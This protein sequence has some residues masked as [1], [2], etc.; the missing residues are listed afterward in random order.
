MTE[1]DLFAAPSGETAHG[2]PYPTPDDTVNVPRDI[3]ALAEELDLRIPG[4]GAEG[5]LNGAS[6]L[7]VG[8]P[9]Q[10][11]AG[12][13][14]TAADFTALGLAAPLGLWNLSDVS[15][16]S[17]NGRALSN[18][19]AVPFGVGINGQAS[20]AAVFAGSTAQALYIA[21]TGAA[22]PFR[23]RTGSIGCWLRTAKRGTWQSCITKRRVGDTISYDIGISGASNVARAYWTLDGATGV[24]LDGVSDVADD[25]WHFVVLTLDG[26]TMRLYVDGVLEAMMSS[27]SPFLGGAPLNI[28]GLAAD[29]ATATTNPHYGRVDE[30]F[31]TADVLSEDQTR[32]LYCAKIA[33]GYAL[34]PTRATLAVRRRRRGGPL[35]VADFPTPPLRLHNFTDGSLSDEGSGAV[36]LTNNGGAVS[37]VA[38]DGTRGGAFSF[39]GAQSLSATDAGL[40]AGAATRSD[41]C[42][43]KLLPGGAMALVGWGTMPNDAETLTVGGT[44]G[45]ITSGSGT[46][47][48]T[49]PYVRDGQWHFAVATNDNTAGDGLRRKLYLDGRLVASSTVLGSLILA[50]ATRFRIGANP[51]ASAPLIG[52]IDGAFVCGYALTFEQVAALYAKGSQALASSPKNEGDHVEHFDA[53]SVYATFDT[54]DSTAQVDLGVAT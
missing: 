30:V 4:S 45:L 22:D 37:V 52:Q 31:V 11:R 34:T 39:A 43:F 53:A 38:A 36:A 15:D 42:W 5:V 49:G 1:P 21:D 18:K 16:A 24:A 19:G 32:A 10:V 26:T 46:D 54:L 12:R 51:D 7:D 8:M 2:L 6:V 44:T 14:L 50:G 13:Q 20:T 40:P 23:I 9:G 35:V 47:F 41:G 28:G 27:A 48:M 17:G 25:R 29:A 33:H 3:Q